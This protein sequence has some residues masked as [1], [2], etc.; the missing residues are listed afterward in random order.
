MPAAKVIVIAVAALG[1]A[2]TAIGCLLAGLFELQG[3]GRPRDADP[4]PGYLA[5]LG[6]GFVASV[7]VPLGLWRL[8][9]PGSAPPLGWLVFAGVAVMVLALLGVGLAA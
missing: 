3:F 4:R 8:L 5:L 9:W 2:V 6:A 1:G 7:L